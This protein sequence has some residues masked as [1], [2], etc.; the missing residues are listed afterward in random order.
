MVSMDRLKAEVTK[1]DR[2]TRLSS[3]DI[4]TMYSKR[5]NHRKDEPLLRAL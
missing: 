2:D 1:K 5:E 3:L 4:K